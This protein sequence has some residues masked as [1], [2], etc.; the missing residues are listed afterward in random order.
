MLFPSTDISIK[1]EKKSFPET[2]TPFENTT[3]QPHKNDQDLSRIL[4]LLNK[5]PTQPSTDI[6]ALTSKTP[7]NSSS[8]ILKFLLKLDNENNPVV[9]NNPEIIETQKL[10]AALSIYNNC[11]TTLNKILLSTKNPIIVDTSH[12]PVL[13]VLSSSSS[14]NTSS[15]VVSSPVSNQCSSQKSSPGNKNPEKDSTTNILENN[16]S[17]NGSAKSTTSSK[18]S[19]RLTE[20]K[21]KVL[22]SGKIK[23]DNYV[24]KSKLAIQR[25]RKNS[26]QY[27]Q[28]KS[29]I[30]NNN[31]LKPQKFSFVKQPKKSLSSSY[32]NKK[33]SYQNDTNNRVLTA[34]D[35]HK[36][37]PICHN[38][39]VL[40]TIQSNSVVA[41]SSFVKKA[42]EYFPPSFRDLDSSEKH[43]NQSNANSKLSVS[44]YGGSRPRT[45]ILSS[46]KNELYTELQSQYQQRI[47]ANERGNQNILNLFF[48]LK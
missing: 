6:Q 23:Y 5:K 3:I 35:Y 13:L 17:L 11:P 4:N 43:Q 24:F 2:I 40:K 14:V 47:K 12:H 7:N 37:D 36:N 44:G 30:S 48:N 19:Y 39:N 41:D 8:N 20:S 34:T 38:S 15:L 27:K 10:D 26:K 33:F 45:P 32:L 29:S 25:N 31:L 46:S 22:N 42:W 16:V 18:L 1:R 28:I 21:A 9:E